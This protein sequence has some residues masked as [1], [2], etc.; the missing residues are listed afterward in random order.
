MAIRLVLA[1]SLFMLDSLKRTVAAQ[2][3][4]LKAIQSVIVKR[5]KEWLVRET[6]NAW[7][8]LYTTRN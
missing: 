8:K 7:N 4:T 6:G 5:L 2:P 1:F 3:D